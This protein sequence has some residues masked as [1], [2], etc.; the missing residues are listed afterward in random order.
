MR[1]NL[2][3]KR[4]RTINTQVTCVQLRLNQLVTRDNTLRD[5]IFDWINHVVDNLSRMTHE[6]YTLA[7]LHVL[8]CLK[9]TIPLPT[10][11]QSFFYSCL[12]GVSDT[13]YIQ[14]DTE[15]LVSLN[16]YKQLRPVDFEIPKNKYLGKLMADVAV[17]MVTMFENS[18]IANSAKRIVR[19]VSL[20]NNMKMQEA[21][22]TVRQ[23]FNDESSELKDWLKFNPFFDDQITKNKSHFV[24][25]QW[26]ILQYYETL[27][28]QKGSR[29]F[30]LLPLKGDFVYSFVGISKS[31]LPSVLTLL[32][33]EKRKYIIDKLRENEYNEDARAYLNKLK[34]GSFGS[35]LHTFDDVS[36]DLWK[37]IFPGAFKLETCNREFAFR[38]S[39]NG[40][41]ASVTMDKP[42]KEKMSGALPLSFDGVDGYIGIDP[43]RT[44]IATSYNDKGK[45]TQ[46]STGEYRHMAKMHDRTKWE[47]RLR[48]RMEDY[49]EAIKNLPSLRVSSFDAFCQHTRVVLSRLAFLY[50]VCR[51]QAFRKWRFTASRFA[52]KAM[53]Q[54]AKRII[55][56]HKNPL[57]G[58]GDWSQQDGFLKGSP[59]APVKKLKAVLQTIAKVVDIDEY[60]TSKTCSKCHA[61][62]ENV[63]YDILKKTNKK[64]GEAEEK[65]N[66]KCHEVVRCTNNECTM[67]WQRDKNASK[68]IFHL[69]KCMVDKKGRPKAFQRKSWR[70]ES[71]PTT[72]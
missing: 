2:R 1:N 62:V 31:Y 12:S 14:K 36:G 68:N 20:K 53:Y 60:C 56:N 23:C 55:G 7:N 69:L 13:K 63:R 58:L 43:G 64:D 10:L 35:K 30:S 70:I 71:Q 16:A 66:V 26:Q 39:T 42:E 29:R 33:V 48:E 47:R 37:L 54:V 50:Q 8:R 18:M 49:T 15:F 46:I 51:E 28:N 25:I 67:Y 9:D 19:Y 3:N 41:A 32:D 40:Y 22:K 34:S 5:S 4:S 57:I 6:A 61:K 45:F 11:D 72:S 44:F 24:S 65:H 27:D 52:K 59:K 17:Q 21:E 38:L